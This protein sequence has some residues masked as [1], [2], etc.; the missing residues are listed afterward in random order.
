VRQQLLPRVEG[1]ER[2]M[3]Y[4]PHDEK[5]A[6]PVVAAKKPDTSDDRDQS[7][8]PGRA[9][10]GETI[11]LELGDLLSGGRRQQRPPVLKQ[12]GGADCHEGPREDCDWAGSSHHGT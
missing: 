1:T 6:G 5:P 11:R 2:N 9:K 10:I 12:A 4:H 7:G 3:E 8:R